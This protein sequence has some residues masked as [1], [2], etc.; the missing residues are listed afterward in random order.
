MCPASSRGILDLAR[1]PNEIPSSTELHLG[2][3]FAPF[4]SVHKT[5]GDFGPTDAPLAS[6]PAFPRPAEAPFDI[7]GTHGSSL[8]GKSLIVLDPAHH[9]IV[10]SAADH[11]IGGLISL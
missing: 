11:D 7:H 1:I 9:R 8:P 4:A 2:I 3:R 6:D 5:V 10:G